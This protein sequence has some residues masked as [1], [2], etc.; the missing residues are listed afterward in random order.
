MPSYKSGKWAHQILAMR[1]SDGLWG[2]FHTLSRPVPGKNYT[3][4]QAIRRLCFLGYTADDE[5]IR[6][7]LRR[8][9]QCI[10][11][12]RSIDG[13]SEKK[14]DW[15]FFETLMLAAWLHFFE[16]QNQVALAVAQQWAR[17]VEKAFSGGGYNPEEETAAFLAWKGR[18]PKSEF[19]TGFGMFYHAALLTGV[20]SPETED[21]FLEY[22]L[23]RPGGMFYI[24]DKPL[25]RPPE[26]FSSRSA[27][28]Y[29]A[30]MEV[31][32]RYDRAR[33]KL[34]FV[35]DWLFANQNE[36]GQWD[37]GEK[38]RDGIYFPLSDRWDKTARLADST[39]R[40]RRFLFSLY[41]HPDFQQV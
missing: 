30:A 38:A 11:G 2:N 5:V 22:L 3:T 21:L 9:E 34:G 29:L 32:S 41:G 23:S 31:L 10:L 28:C 16:P 40:V 15:P 19:E 12:E 6:V 13:Y 35:A 37:F 18:R 36:K 7:V 20:L 4:E 26:V 14:H 39:Y 25:N 27:S 8:M 33:G 24:Y 1:Q 17:V